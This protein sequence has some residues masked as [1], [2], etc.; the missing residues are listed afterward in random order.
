M[1][2][3]RRALPKQFSRWWPPLSALLIAALSVALYLQAVQV[4]RLREQV[5]LAV[6]KVNLLGWN[7]AKIV[8]YLEKTE[9]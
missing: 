8:E 5:R 2:D 6:Y 7:Q 9:P 3:W 1:T 4:S